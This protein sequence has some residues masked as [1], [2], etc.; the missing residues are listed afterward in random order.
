MRNREDRLTM[1]LRDDN[2]WHN[3]LSHKPSEDGMGPVR[4]RVGD[5]AVGNGS[6]GNSDLGQ[7]GLDVN[8]RSWGHQVRS[9]NL[10]HG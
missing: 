4:S 1:C 5:R 10:G 6:T 3:E 7:N 9:T 2:R 8:L